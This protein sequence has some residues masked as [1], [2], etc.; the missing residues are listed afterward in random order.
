MSADRT[1]ATD[2]LLV[3]RCVRCLVCGRRPEYLDLAF[4]EVSG[5]ALLV[6][7]CVLCRKA[8]PDMTKLLALL[9]RRYSEV[10]A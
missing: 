7:R 1:I 5:L 2:D 4:V 8:D 3:Q 10:P 6:A 9:E